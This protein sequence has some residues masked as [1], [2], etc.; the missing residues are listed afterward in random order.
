MVL[1]QCQNFIL[2]TVCRHKHCLFRLWDTNNR[3]LNKKKE[4]DNCTSLQN[5][6]SQVGQMSNQKDISSIDNQFF[7]NSEQFEKE[8]DKIIKLGEYLKNF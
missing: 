7:I 4:T 5:Y 3:V 6:G 1:D 8:L 2:A